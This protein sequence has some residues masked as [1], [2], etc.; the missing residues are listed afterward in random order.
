M[1]TQESFGFERP[2]V[3][4]RRAPRLVWIVK[5]GLFWMVDD[6]DGVLPLCPAYLS[7]DEARQTAARRFKH[8]V[9]QLGAPPADQVAKRNRKAGLLEDARRRG[10]VLQ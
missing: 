6:G 7:V 5:A 9:V 1:N 10:L 2:I 3:A 8:A 4:E